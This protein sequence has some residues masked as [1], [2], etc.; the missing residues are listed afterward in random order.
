MSGDGQ[1]ALT[2]SGNT[3]AVWSAKEQRR[4][5]ALSGHSAGFDETALV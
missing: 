3:A 2:V 4:I 5:A 1:R